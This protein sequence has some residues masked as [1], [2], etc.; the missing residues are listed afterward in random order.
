MWALLE[1]GENMS[2][3][4]GFAGIVTGISVVALIF[5]WYLLANWQY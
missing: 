4:W 1:L 3:K 2:T 5:A